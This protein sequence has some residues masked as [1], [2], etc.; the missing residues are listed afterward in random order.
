MHDET[1][2]FSH[3]DYARLTDAYWINAP[4]CPDGLCACPLDHDEPRDLEGLA[5][6]V[7]LGLA[8]GTIAAGVVYVTT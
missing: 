1:N 4:H 5:R 2:R 6:L 3:R 8:V 7:M